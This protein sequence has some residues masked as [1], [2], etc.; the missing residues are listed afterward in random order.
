MSVT[1]KKKLT[2]CI[3]KLFNLSFAK[4]RTICIE[5]DQYGVLINPAMFVLKGS[6]IFV[7][8]VSVETNYVFLTVSKTF[9]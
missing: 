9:V 1:F 5:N 8:D 3:E 7:P 6:K 4:C 2:A